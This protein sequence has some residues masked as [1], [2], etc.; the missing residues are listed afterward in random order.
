MNALTKS[1]IEDLIR[2]DLSLSKMALETH[3]EIEKELD[4]IEPKPADIILKILGL[5]NENYYDYVCSILLDVYDGELTIY[6]AID[7]LEQ[8]RELLVK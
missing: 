2:M 6:E 3:Q 1:I 7:R 8:E 5:N 4:F